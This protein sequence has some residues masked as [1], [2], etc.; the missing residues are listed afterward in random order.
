[1]SALPQPLERLLGELIRDR[2]FDAQSV[3]DMRQ[4]LIAIDHEG[5]DNP[6]ALNFLQAIS[7]VAAQRGSAMERFEAIDEIRRLPR[8]PT[9]LRI[10]RPA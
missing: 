9:T 1:M 7:L 6:H 5:D 2:V 3:M 4:A 10:A 8:G